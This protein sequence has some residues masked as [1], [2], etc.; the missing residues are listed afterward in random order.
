M[1]V[2]AQIGFVVIGYLI[3]AISFARVVG[4]RRVPEA[5]LS[6]TEFAVEG[7]EETWVYTGV[8]A[9]SVIDRA[10]A[11]WGVLV[12]VLD[13]LKALVPTLATRLL[14]PDDPVYLFVAVAVIIG[15]VWPVWH[16]FQG[17]RGQSPMLGAML[18]VDA[19]AIPAAIVVAAIVGLVVFTSAHWARDG[20]PFGVAPWFA[21]TTGWSAKT[22][23]GLTLAVIYLMAIW[24]D[25]AEERRVRAAL[26]T[27]SLPWRRRLS[28][29]VKDFVFAQ[30]VGSSDD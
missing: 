12:V 3:G 27:S 2:A 13:A 7:S 17:G 19:L 8:S 6:Q 22:A 14:W 15:H 5:D 23:F 21:I 11:I 9:T 26:G 30:D 24:P 16:R 18:V 4:S 28:V 29:A 10:G 1:V 20:S 25:I